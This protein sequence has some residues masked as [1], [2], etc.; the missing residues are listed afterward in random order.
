MNQT[1][2][3]APQT[4]Q[5]QV[6]HQEDNLITFTLFGEQ[7]VPQVQGA[8][9]NQE[10]R[11]RQRSPR[12]KKKSEW[13]LNQRQFD[14]S[15]TQEISH[16]LPGEH[17]NVF[18]G[19]EPSVSYL[20]LPVKKKEENRFCTRCGEMGHGKRFCQAATWCKFCTLDTHATKACQRY[21]KF[22][23]DNPIASS[24]RNTLVQEQKIAV[25]VQESNQQPLFPN[26][27]VQRFNAA[28][29]PPPGT[30][31]LAPRVEECESREHYQKSP[32]NQIRD[33]RVPMSAQLPHQ[34][35]CQDIR[36][37][38]CYQKPPQ[39]AEINYHRP[40]PQT[41][42]EVNEIGPT[43]QQGMIQCPVQRHT[44]AAGE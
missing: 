12:K 38:P 1:T 20:P 41:P 25:N 17:L 3:P 36:V 34:R 13:T 33:T 24:R 26:L 42:I 9:G 11:K 28:V 15:K 19:E 6:S 10:Q 7:Q 31:N 32:Q 29:I 43:I 40:S 18:N 2:P 22:V 5:I 8:V 23:R 27:P 37:D 16:I 44:Q 21:E 14:Q 4:P 39:Y 35:S 30:N